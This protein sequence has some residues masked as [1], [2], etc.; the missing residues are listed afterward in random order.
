MIIGCVKL[1]AQMTNSRVV[2]PL[3]TRPPYR[4]RSEQAAVPAD[5]SLPLRILI[6]DDS[7]EDRI[8]VRV[9]L[10][11][12]G[13]VLIEAASGAAGLLAAQAQRPDCILLDYQLPDKD[14]LEVLE[15]LRNSDGTLPCAVVMLTGTATTATAVSAMRLGAQDYLNKDF[16]NED[17]LQRAV[18][19]ATEGFQRIAARRA[20]DENNARLAAII[21]AS[22]DGIISIGLDRLIGSWNPGATR[23]FGYSEMEALGRP[24]DEL[25]VPGD[26]PDQRARFLAVVKA[27]EQVMPTEAYVSTKAGDLIPVEINASPILDVHNGLRGV[28]VIFRDIRERT[29]VALRLR[30]SE[31]R[32]Q[33]T[34]DTV[35]V[36]ISESLPDGRYFAVNDHLCRM[37]G[38][39]RDELLGLSALG[40]TH[41]DDLELTKSLLRPLVAGELDVIKYEKRYVHKNGTSVWVSVS[42][43]AVRDERHSLLYAVAAIADITE[44]RQAEQAL[45]DRGAQLARVQRLGKIGGFEVDLSDASLPSRRSIEYMRI[46]GLPLESTE[47]THADWLRRVHPDDRENADRAIRD[48]LQAGSTFYSGE[49]R[50][51]RPSDGR[52]RWVWA[53][54]EIERDAEGCEQRLVGAHVD[55]TE[56]KRTELA[57]AKSRARLRQAADATRLTY[58]ELDFERGRTDLAENFA[59]I[60]GLASAMPSVPVGDLP[61]TAEL[62]LERVNALDRPGVEAAFADLL[63]GRSIDKLEYRVRGDDNVERWFES[64]VALEVSPASKPLRGFATILDVSEQ[65]RAEERIRLLMGEVNHRSKNLLAVVQ[66]IA[67]QTARHS[68]AETFVTRFSERVNGLAESQNLLVDSEWQGI[69]IATLVRAQLGHVK[70]MIGDRVQLAGPP[71]RLSPSAA[72]GIGMALHELATNASKYGAL[73]VDEGRIRIIWDVV[74]GQNEAGDIG[75]SAEKLFSIQWIEED[76]PKVVPPTRKGFGQL[77]TLRMVEA[78]VGGSAHVDYAPDGLRWSLTA[79]VFNT[80]E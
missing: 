68:D 65:K 51:I 75:A 24:V 64:V 35:G 4:V 72:Q 1:K 56:R 41:P 38:Y 54:G 74:S 13:F 17:S 9:A 50:V 39:T 69:Q 22:N 45:R 23:L 49:Y 37:L 6:I 18:R 33:I 27:S 78:A 55:I 46:H 15:A 79:P 77:V 32:L 7:P 66:S 14:G 73:S 58:L 28:S 62:V 8:I 36:G 67:R 5:A 43:T 42:T 63:A 3:A 10:E 80:L 44:R 19:G 26:R 30:E 2:V 53:V 20:A 59:A 40:L 60:L 48:T 11:P 70:D 34:L 29:A 25:F 31:R 76:G 61:A 12:Q 71:V 47:E 21:A 16:F 52:V 57:L